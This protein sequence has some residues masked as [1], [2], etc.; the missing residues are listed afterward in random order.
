MSDVDVTVR[1][2]RKTGVHALALARGEV[3]NDNV[4]YK[5]R[6]FGNIHGFNLSVLRG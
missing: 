4:L 3:V 5:I 1:L 2:G 6:G